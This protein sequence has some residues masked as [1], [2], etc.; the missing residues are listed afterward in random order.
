MNISRFKQTVE[1]CMAIQRPML[2]TSQPGVGKSQTIKQ[3]AD[4]IGG[5]I[6]LRVSSMAPED[7]GELLYVS[8]GKVERAAPAYLPTK[9]N[10]RAKKFPKRG[11]L[12]LD[13]ICD[14]PPAV[15]SALYELVLD[16]K[17][18]SAE[19]A[20]GWY[21]IGA[22]NRKEDRAA[23]TQKMSSALA[24]RFIHIKLELDHEELIKYA[25]QN[26][27][28]IMVPAFLNFQPQYISTFDPKSKEDAFAS[29]RTWE[30]TSDILNENPPEEVRL[31]I[32]SGTIGEGVATILEGFM[33]IKDELV[34]RDEI[35]N[36]PET[37]DVPTNPSAV[38]AVCTMLSYIADI[39]NID[40]IVKYTERLPAEFSMSCISTAL[41]QNPELHN[42]TA[43]AQVWAPKYG[44]LL[45][46]NN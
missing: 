15:A 3:V 12:L 24:N 16:R 36:N 32:L 8:K 4:T 35:L 28:N 31:E 42:T 21:I 40:S 6:D 23:V 2:V 18:G 41:N 46:G 14:A 44:H 19:I 45:T 10:V 43:I 17:T 38:H 20:D 33:R 9:E 5:F 11:I 29:P 25:F 1:F 7:I 22:G 39:D 27:W 13:E 26:N 34:D 30:Y 37:A